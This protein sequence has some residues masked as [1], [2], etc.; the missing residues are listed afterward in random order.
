M[1]KSKF[2][3]K[4][5]DGT[6]SERE[7]LKVEF[8]KESS[9]Y[10]KDIEKDSVKYVSGF[11]L[12]KDG[13]SEEQIH[14]YEEVLEDYYDLAQKTMAEFFTEQGLDASRLAKKNFIKANISDFK[15]I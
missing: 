11:E 4:K 1:Q 2:T 12:K 6:V 14:Q 13:L 3:Y 7:L 10:L 15:V 5:E 9:N 8:L